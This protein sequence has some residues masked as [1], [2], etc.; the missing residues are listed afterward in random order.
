MRVATG[1]KARFCVRDLSSLTP[2]EQRW[3]DVWELVVG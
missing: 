3:K 2:L 1:D